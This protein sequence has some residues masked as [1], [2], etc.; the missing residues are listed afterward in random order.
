MHLIKYITGIFLVIVIST[1]GIPCYMVEDASHDGTVDLQDA[2]LQVKGF[3]ESADGSA[4]F[5]FSFEKMLDTLSSVAGLK[6]LIDPN[7]ESKSSQ[8]QVNVSIS[9]DKITNSFSIRVPSMLSSTAEYFQNIFLYES[10]T[11][12]PSIRPPRIS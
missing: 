4:S 12:D 3:A 9:L 1:T 6:T 11:L 2:I 5:G 8:N 7:K 10:R